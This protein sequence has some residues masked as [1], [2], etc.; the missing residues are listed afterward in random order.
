MAS[1]PAS[2]AVD[3]LRARVGA[4]TDSALARLLGVAPIT[5]H[6]WRKRNRVP[7]SATTF[8]DRAAPLSRTDLRKAIGLLPTDVRRAFVLELMSGELGG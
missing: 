5:V 6:R 7:A 3:E 4:R 1:N 2:N 8:P